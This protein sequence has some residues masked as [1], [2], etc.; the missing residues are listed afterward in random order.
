M[1]LWIIV[2]RTAS[3]FQAAEHHEKIPLDDD[4]PQWCD[5]EYGSRVHVLMKLLKCGR[6]RKKNESEQKGG[7][8]A[9]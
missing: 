2:R 1:V 3:N 7:N 5:R 9:P 6:G 8:S 4:G